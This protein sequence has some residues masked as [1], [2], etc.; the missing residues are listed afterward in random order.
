MI[1]HLPPNERLVSK[2]LTKIFK[3]SEDTSG[4]KRGGGEDK[5]Y[6][7]LRSNF[8]ELQLKNIEIDFHN[9]PFNYIIENNVKY[10]LRVVKDTNDSFRSLI[11]KEYSEIARLQ[12]PIK[13][14]DDTTSEESIN[15]EEVFKQNALKCIDEWTVGINGE[16][17]RASLRML[18][19]QY[20]C[21]R[22][23]KLFSDQINKTFMEVQDEINNYYINEIKSVDRL[24]KYLQMA[25]ENGR[26]IPETLVLEH[27]TFVIDPNLLQFAPVE[28]PRE[29]GVETELVEPME[30]KISQLATLRSQFKIVA[31]HG[32]TLQQAF[33]YLLQDF[34]FFGK[35][36]CNGHLFPEA[37]VNIDPEQV[38]KLVYMLFGDTVYVDWRDFLIYC[39]NLR[40]PTV[41]ELLALRKR[42][43]C[44]DL[45]S[46]ELIRRDDFIEE[47]LWFEREFDPDDKH[48][49]LRKNLIKHFLFELFEVEEDMM[50]Y[51]AFLLAFCK[52]I[53][54]I[55]G[56]VNALSMAIG[57][58]T[59][60]TPEDCE[61]VICKL[62]KLKKYKDAC[63]ACAMKCT[64]EFLDTL[65]LKVVNYCEGTTITELLYVPPPEDKKGK[66]GKGGKG[67]GSKR[68]EA[69]QSARLPKV[70][71][72][73]TSKSKI[74]QSETNVKTFICRPCE[75]ESEVEEKP[76]EKPEHKEEVHKVE[77]I[78]NP[79][80]SYA[81]SQAVIWNILRICLP[82]HFVLVPE[83]QKTPYIDDVTGVMK[84]LEVDTDNGD[85]YISRFVIDPII[86]KLL[87][88]V[89]KFTALNLGEAVHKIFV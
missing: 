73:L 28:P 25:V 83:H 40:F 7:Q 22:D 65:L 36:S 89:K 46:T 12:P 21:Y 34:I 26:R 41:E 42:F 59:C 74:A 5:T 27:D 38:P 56:F 60:Y 49:Q 14:K 8:Q 13:K 3:E 10:A 67:Q 52:D 43:R 23:M 1:R 18:A 62:I 50:N 30:F 51:S 69:S 53:D 19:L 68:V 75:D 80:L 44:N 78:E 35:E 55:K 84:R 81:I 45:S 77:T 85:I 82:W 39:L 64:K 16:M 76:V 63:L 87:H 31:P 88:K 47:E 72:S 32:I 86:C 33:I 29:P 20:K 70:Q 58:Q 54:P 37:W 11:A 9:N 15:V 57:K 17:Y 2:E 6:K 61:E 66:K 71:K 79:N 48:M 4:S 24:C